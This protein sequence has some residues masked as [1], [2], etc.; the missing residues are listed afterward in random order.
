MQTSTTRPALYDY[1]SRIV[2]VLIT[3]T[4]PD[5][6]E[7]TLLLA[8]VW[9]EISGGMMDLAL[10]KESSSLMETL[11]GA[12]DCDHLAT[13]TE[14]L[15]RERRGSTGF[16]DLIFNPYGSFVFGMYNKTLQ[17]YLLDSFLWRLLQISKDQTKVKGLSQRWVLFLTKFQTL[18]HFLRRSLNPCTLSKETTFVLYCRCVT[19]RKTGGTDRLPWDKP[20]L[21]FLALPF[22]PLCFSQLWTLFRTLL[23]PIFQLWT[24]FW[25]SPFELPQKT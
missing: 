17:S 2:A 7:R 23:S 14:I 19:R 3:E 10:D 5:P 15:T 8:N 4:Q 18:P 6:E 25:P 9:S 16:L 13:F 20:Q 22:A 21:Q 12:S 24:L 11:I 1:L